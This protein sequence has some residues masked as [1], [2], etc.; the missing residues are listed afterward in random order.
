MTTPIIS[1]FAK[2]GTPQLIAASGLGNRPAIY[3][4]RQMGIADYFTVPAP[5]T[6]TERRDLSM[7]L[8]TAASAF[9]RRNP[10]MSFSTHYT[11]GSLIVTRNS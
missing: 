6:Q 9:A 2:D 4:F 3:P 7:R 5:E 11:S 10:P 8:Y 1:L